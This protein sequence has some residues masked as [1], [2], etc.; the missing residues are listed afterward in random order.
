MQNMIL[1]QMEA[2]LVEKGDSLPWLML[3]TMAEYIYGKIWVGLLA[4]LVSAE[5]KMSVE[6]EYN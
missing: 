1:P 6:S 5:R 2:R 4:V 3:G